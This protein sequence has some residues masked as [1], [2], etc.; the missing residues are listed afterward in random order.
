MWQFW[1]K[2]FIGE[3][4]VSGDKSV[5]LR[6]SRTKPK[7]E[8]IERYVRKEC[9]PHLWRM[10]IQYIPATEGREL[11]EVSERT[12]VSDEDLVDFIESVPNWQ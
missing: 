12:C 10:L 3:G 2:T 4:N 6:L 7:D 8:T 5:L 9:R 11:S 1:R